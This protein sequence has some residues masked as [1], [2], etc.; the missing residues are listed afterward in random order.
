LDE[1]HPTNP[2][3]PYGKTKL[4]IEEIL[5][6]LAASD[7]AWRIIALRYFNPVGAHES[8]LIGEDPNGIPNNL[9]PYISQVAS[10]SLDK[11][12]IFGNDYDTPDG[13]GV[14]DYIHVMDLAEGHI[15]ALHHLSK[16][17]QNYSIINLG[18]GSGCSVLELVSI[19]EK[20]SLKKIPYEISPRRPGDIASCYASVDKVVS[21]V[22]WRAT[23]SLKIACEDAYRWQNLI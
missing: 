12:K 10:G 14:R 3:S 7:K 5:K 15:A 21:L 9:M 16:Q 20:S 1:D 6:D 22:G 23:R 8:G 19:Y 11:L 2:Q 4:Q 13:T 18:S 17:S